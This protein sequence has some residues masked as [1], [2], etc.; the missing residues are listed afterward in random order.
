MPI[1]LFVVFA[2]WPVVGMAVLAVVDRWLYRFR[3]VKLTSADR[4]G[5]ILLRMY[6]WPVVCWKSWRSAGTATV[7]AP[8]ASG[9]RDD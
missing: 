3:G 8:P 7:A 4:P 6:L 2:A 5:E 9:K 1:W